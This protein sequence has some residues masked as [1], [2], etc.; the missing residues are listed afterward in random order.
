VG[1]RFDLLCALVL[2][3]EEGLDRDWLIVSHDLANKQ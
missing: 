3:L 2:E 1:K